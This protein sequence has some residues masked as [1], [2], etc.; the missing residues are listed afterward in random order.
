MGRRGQEE[1][2]QVLTEGPLA[3]GED[4]ASTP[5]GVPVVVGNRRIYRAQDWLRAADLELMD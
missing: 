1:V 5:W 2:K 3:R 4:G